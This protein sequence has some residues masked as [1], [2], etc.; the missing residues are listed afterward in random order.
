MKQKLKDYLIILMFTIVV[1][2]PLLN[3][4]LDVYRDD[5]VQHIARLMGTYQSI[6][7]GENPP[8]ITSNFCN[9]FGYSWNIFYSPLTAYLPLI[10]R[11]FTNSFE[12]ILKMFMF[13]LSFLSGIAMYEF[14]KNITKNN[15]AAI[16]AGILYILAPYR[17]TD[18]YMRVAISELASF[19][20]L[21]VL[22][23]GMYNIFN[24]NI[25]NSKG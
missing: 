7:G 8:V 2:I 3:K 24:L 1:C 11:I 5:G 14:V 25:R 13:L 10:L 16:L 22:F 21:P 12:V 23:Q 9:E 15:N 6:T 19:V 17:L 4:N 20:F 18:M